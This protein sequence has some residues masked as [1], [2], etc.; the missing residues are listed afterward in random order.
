MPDPRRHRE[1]RR[2]RQRRATVWAR[3]ADRLAD[4]TVA[5]L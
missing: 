1:R 5:L 3:V 2:H 4:L